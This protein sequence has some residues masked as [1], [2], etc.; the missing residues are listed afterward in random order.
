MGAELLREGSPPPTC[1][2]S[3]VTCHMSHVTCHM[4]QRGSDGPEFFITFYAIL[5]P[6]L[7]FLVFRIHI[8]VIFNLMLH[9]YIVMYCCYMHIQ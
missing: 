6:L 2:V 1:H 8:G 9:S 4:S 3:H 7:D 5:M